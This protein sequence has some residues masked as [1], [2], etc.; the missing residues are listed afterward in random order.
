[1]QR[2]SLYLS[3]LF[4]FVFPTATIGQPNKKAL[5]IAHLTGDFYIYTTYSDYKGT[6]YPANGMY[7]ITSAGAVI[8]DSPWDTTQFQPL[9]DSIKARHNTDAVMCLATHFHDDRTGGLAY[10]ASKGIKTYTTRKTD[11]LSAIHDMKRAEFLIGRDTIFQIGQHRFQVVYPGQ[12]HAPDN[13]VVWFE[14]ARVL[15]G[16]CLIKSTDDTHLGNLAD[17]S[18][19]DYATTIQNVVQRCPDPRYVIPGHKGWHDA[20]SLQHTLRMAQALKEKR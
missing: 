2:T 9:L 12:G 3:I 11:S 18:V 20:G 4:S 10:Y 8:I 19:E 15:Y 1:M 14:N 16:G 6:R 17:A 5:E 13:I 7:V